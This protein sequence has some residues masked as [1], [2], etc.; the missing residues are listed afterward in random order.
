MDPT[1]TPA[2]WWAALLDV[3]GAPASPLAGSAAGLVGSYV[4]D[5]R[6]LPAHDPAAGPVTLSVT[7][8][9]GQLSGPAALAGR[10]GVVLHAVRVVLRDLDD[11]R[12]NAR[13]V[14]AAVDDARAAGSL[15][16]ATPVV[17]ALPDLEPGADW[18]GAVDEVAAR[19]LA[20]A[21][22]L[23]GTDGPADP[24]RVAA[25]LAAGFDRETPVTVLGGDPLCVLGAARRAFDGA[26]A[27][28]VAAAL[29]GRPAEAL[30]GL[31]EVAL[32]GVR[33]WLLGVQ[34]GPDG[35]TRVAADLA[36][37]G[38]TQPSPET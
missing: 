20:L 4:V 31:D 11:L 29:S 1:T 22:P 21:L 18:L 7:G 35:P 24:L 10:R 30:E 2:P 8:G 5:D 9:A 32:V 34:C 36:G 33:R 37:L 26:G 15:D 14:V 13:R 23:V 25:W 19:E 28:E 12:G 16:P 27:V 6:A 17:V 3:T 38:I